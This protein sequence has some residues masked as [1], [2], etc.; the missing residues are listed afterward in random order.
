MFRTLPL[1]HCKGTSLLTLFLCGKAS[2]GGTDV[3]HLNSLC[4]LLLNLSVVI[5]EAPQ[6]DKS[7][8]FLTSHLGLIIGLL[9]QV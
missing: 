9:C 1:S 5:G 4:E 8:H 3:K 2:I 7:Q 6:V